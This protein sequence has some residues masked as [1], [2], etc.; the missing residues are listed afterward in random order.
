MKYAA[1]WFVGILATF[2]IVAAIGV[3]GWKLHWWMAKSTVQHQYDINTN[4]QQWQSSKIDQ[5]RNLSHDYGVAVDPGQKLALSSQFCSIYQL[6]T[7]P[8]PA[9]GT[10][11][12]AAIQPTI[13]G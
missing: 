13:C 7:P 10:A 11:D 6:I 4:T 12:L 2:V 3:G 5:L 8:P 9:N 1:A